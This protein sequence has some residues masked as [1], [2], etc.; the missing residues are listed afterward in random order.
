ML[1][2]DLERLLLLRLELGHLELQLAEAAVHLAQV[3]VLLVGR[4]ADGGD[5]GALEGGER[6][7][8]VGRGELLE[9]PLARLVEQLGHRGAH[10]VLDG[11]AG[12]GAEVALQH[13]RDVPAVGPEGLLELRVQ[14]GDHGLGGLLEVLAQD[15]DRRAGL[16]AVEDAGADLD[17]VGD[18]A[19]GALA[20]VR[21]R[22][23]ELGGERVVDDEVLDDH[24]P[25]QGGDAGMAKR[26]GGFHRP[27]QA[28]PASG[29]ISGR[30]SRARPS[31]ASSLDLE[32]RDLGVAR[33]GAAELDQRVDRVRLA[34]EHRLDGAVAAVA[35]P[36]GH[37][38]PSRL[39][40]HRIAEEHA[41]HAPVRAY[42]PP[43]SHGDTV[44]RHGHRRGARH[45]HHRARGGR[46]RQRGQHAAAARR[47]RGG[48]DL[49]RR[50]PGGRRRVGRQG[51]DR[52]RR[53]GRDDGRRHARAVGHP[54]RDDG[55]RRADVGRHRAPRDGLHARARG[56]A[57]RPQPRARGLRHR[58]RRL[59]AGRRRA[60]RGRGGP[61]PPRRAA[62]SSS[63]SC[64]RC[65]A[66]PP[67]GRSRPHWIERRRAA[68]ARRRVGAARGHRPDARAAAARAAARP[69]GARQA[70]LRLPRAGRRRVR[71]RRPTP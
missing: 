27:S 20:G 33:P 3:R 47:R 49:A 46:D 8:L 67:A 34:L 55:A 63:A 18:H 35:G 23:H 22:A 11:G 26:R 30:R 64:S 56:R 32:P 42:A 25:E 15:L 4:L 39:A 71:R 54:R 12:L 29:G 57:R 16:L 51:A 38:A 9:Q 5:R 59:P 48:R 28:R 44:D 52:A 69:R 61:P 60:D 2:G 36:P 6:V 53:G 50:R 13:A 62:R 14:L 1:G 31:G 7:R 17:R 19:L 37:A 43:D 24:P 41:L 65:T 40:P 10:L 58:R 66:T 68:R 45:R 21:P 70:A